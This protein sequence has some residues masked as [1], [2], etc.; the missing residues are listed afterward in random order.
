VGRAPFPLSVGAR[1]ARDLRSKTAGNRFDIPNAGVLYFA[2]ELEA[3]FAETLADLR[4]KPALVDLVRDE[5]NAAN[6]LKPCA[7]PASWRLRRT[8]VKVKVDHDQKF[9][10]VTDMQTILTLRTELA[11]RLSS[12]GYSDLDMGL[13]QGADRR[14]T[15]MISEWAYLQTI[16]QE[17]DYDEDLYRFAGIKYTS[18]LNHEWTCWA[19]FPDVDLAQVEA[20]PV[21]RETPE[22]LAIAERFGLRI[23]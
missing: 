8:A 18:R 5:W 14:V 7:V 19:V 23:F 21:E 22:L 12:I 15:R 1:K 16:D 13:V 9:L 20:A 11:L 4:A 2:D 3:C 10:D 17:S 6:W